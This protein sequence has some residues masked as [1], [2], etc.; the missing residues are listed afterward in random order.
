MTGGWHM[1]FPKFCHLFIKN[2]NLFRQ[3]VDFENESMSEF[4]SFKQLIIFFILLQ[5]LALLVV[6]VP[7]LDRVRLHVAVGLGQLQNVPG[8]SLWPL[9]GAL[10]RALRRFCWALWHHGPRRVWRCC[11]VCVSC[12]WCPSCCCGAWIAG[13]VKPRRTVWYLE[14]LIDWF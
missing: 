12:R 10:C 11:D 9:F 7:P 5:R 13:R 1:L 4:N 2:A 14:T 8:P 6:G 3:L